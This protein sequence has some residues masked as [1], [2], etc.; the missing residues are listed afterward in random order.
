MYLA[1]TSLHCID[2][3]WEE[4]AQAMLRPFFPGINC[5]TVPCDG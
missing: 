4:N 2:A 5:D 1:E 3:C